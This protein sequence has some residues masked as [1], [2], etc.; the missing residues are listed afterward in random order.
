MGKQARLG[1]LAE[2]E[3]VG[4]TIQDK[5]NMEISGD[6]DYSECSNNLIKVTGENPF[7]GITLTLAD[8]ANEGDINVDDIRIGFSIYTVTM[9]CELETL[10]LNKFLESLVLTQTPRT[11]I[12]ATL[13]TIHLENIEYKNRQRLGKFYLELN[14][15]FNFQHGRILMALSSPWEL[16]GMMAQ[17]LP[18]LTPY[19]QQVEECVSGSSCQG[20]NEL[21]ND[22]GNY[23][24]SS[25]T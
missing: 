17:D 16:D 10:K 21:I 14:K 9:M 15:T 20:L 4:R 24:F 18:Y 7:E 19:K 5:Y 22:L 13:N 8:V 1:G 23:Q 2:D 11:I 25:F 3:A 6:I 12:Q